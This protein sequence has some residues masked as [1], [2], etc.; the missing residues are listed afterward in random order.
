MDNLEERILA[1]IQRHMDEQKTLPDEGIKIASP[2]VDMREIKASL[3]KLQDQGII[4]GMPLNAYVPYI[5]KA[6]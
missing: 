6:E 3:Q 2:S 1:I 4:L 5:K